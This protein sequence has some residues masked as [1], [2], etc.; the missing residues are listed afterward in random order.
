MDAEIS[1]GNKIGLSSMTKIIR[2]LFP[3]KPVLGIALAVMLLVEGAAIAD[4][5]L[6]NNAKGVEGVWVEMA[7]NSV[8]PFTKMCKYERRLD[9]CE[10]ETYNPGDVHNA[11]WQQSQF[12]HHSIGWSS[13]IPKTSACPATPSTLSS[14]D[15]HHTE[16][17][18]VP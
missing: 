1:S 6:E 9:G 11:C 10:N 16:T 3:A 18:P 12:G 15:Q 14:L 8:G 5:L 2:R 7:Q 17:R 4:T 13:E